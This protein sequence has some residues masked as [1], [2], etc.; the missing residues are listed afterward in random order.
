MRDPDIWQV[1]RLLDALPTTTRTTS[2]S[3]SISKYKTLWATWA[4]DTPNAVL[5][6]IRL[7][8]A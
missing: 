3:T 2:K 4:F 5:S 1:P 8:A 6:P 7:N